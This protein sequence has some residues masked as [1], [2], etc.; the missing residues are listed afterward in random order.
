[1]MPPS[2]SLRRGV[3]AL[4]RPAVDGSPGRFHSKGSGS[5]IR[6]LEY[7]GPKIGAIIAF[8]PSQPNLRDRVITFLAHILRTSVIVRF[9]LGPFSIPSLEV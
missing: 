4:F 6:K 5:F 1:M 8:P 2:P 3:E 9:P 7:C